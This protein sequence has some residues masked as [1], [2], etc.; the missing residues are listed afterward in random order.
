MLRNKL[1]YIKMQND[2]IGAVIEIWMPLPFAYIRSL[3]ASLLKNC[4]CSL[5]PKIIRPITDHYR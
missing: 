3:Y 1:T 4:N 2:L 5:Q